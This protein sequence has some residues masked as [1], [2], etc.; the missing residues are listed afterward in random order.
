MHLTFNNL[1]NNY[2]NYK[3]IKFVKFSKSKLKY[4]AIK[5]FQEIVETQH[6]L[7]FEQK[8]NTHKLIQNFHEFILEI[9]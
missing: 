8:S 4:S 7:N 9:N 5:F 2:K 3:H 6:V 1:N